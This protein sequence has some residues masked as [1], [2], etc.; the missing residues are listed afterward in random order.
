MGLEEALEK[1]RSDR[2]VTAAF[3]LEGEIYK[4]VVGEEGSVTESTFGMPL[5]NRA[6]EEV[7]KRE[8]AVCIFC[9]GS[10]EPPSDHVMVMEDD[11]GNLVGHDIPVCRMGEFKDDPN[12]FWLCDDFVMYPNKTESQDIVMV[13]LPQKVCSIGEDEGVRDLILMYP[14]TTTDILLRKHFGVS[15]DDPKIASAIM[16]FNVL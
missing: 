13:M 5:I 4:E 10:F 11:R 7:M 9:D 16:A 8:I 1:I 15:V 3:V 2:S 14:A 12:I 6:L